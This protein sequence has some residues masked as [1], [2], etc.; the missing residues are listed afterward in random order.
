VSTAAAGLDDECTGAGNCHGC[1]RW[2]SRCGDVA[3]VCDMR[4]RGERCDEHPVPPSVAELRLARRDAERRIYE[5][6]RL[7]R[8]AR[9]AIEEV[10]EGE[11][12]RREYSA[13]VEE[14]ERR[15]FERS[16]GR[17]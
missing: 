10:A 13:Q 7:T 5:G 15:M 14:Q 9:A 16:G 8:D 4:L 6:E 12:A 17:G 11:R 2:C 3:H 1:V